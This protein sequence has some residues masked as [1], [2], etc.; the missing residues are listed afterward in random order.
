M[1]AAA[2]NGRSSPPD[3]LVDALRGATGDDAGRGR[4]V[5][6]RT[7][8]IR[9]LAGKGRG[10]RQLIAGLQHVPLPKSATDALRTLASNEYFFWTGR[11]LRKS[12][13]ADWQRSLRRVFEEAKVTGNAHMFRHTF[14]TDLLARGVPI[15]DVAILL[16]HATPAVTAK[17][18]AHFVK[19]RR[20]RL[21]ERV[22][23]LW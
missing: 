17:Y 6:E 23:Q 10:Y 16:G 1:A 15:E 21:E 18:Y 5:L 14:S 12:A 3:E 19:A 13:V 2:G 20:E 11:G 22:R 9:T 4:R 7:A 8:P